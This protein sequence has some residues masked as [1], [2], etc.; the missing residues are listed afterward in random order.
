MLLRR[1]LTVHHP[2]GIGP[3]YG[4]TGCWKR[5][6]RPEIV[7]IVV[8]ESP[9]I[10]RKIGVFQQPAKLATEGFDHLFDF[11]EKLKMPGADGRERGTDA[12][13][14]ETLFRIIQSIPSPKAEPFK[15]WLAKVAF[16][17]LEESRNPEIAVRRAMLTYQLQGYPDDWISARIKTMVSRKELTSEWARRGVKEVLEY[18]VLTNV[19]SQETFSKSTQDHKEYKSLRVLAK[20]ITCVTT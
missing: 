19:I 4:L 17:R 18:A 12:A 8:S 1:S 15:R 14:T 13:N 2:V 10:F 9:S 7:P 11:I 16:E 3:S 5:G 20:T 6:R